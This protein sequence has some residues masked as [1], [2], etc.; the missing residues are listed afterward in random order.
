[1]GGAIRLCGCL[2]IVTRHRGTLKSLFFYACQCGGGHLVR[3]AR[4]DEGED[5][6]F[7]PV[8]SV[9]SVA[10]V[11]RRKRRTFVDTAWARGK[12]TTT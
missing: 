2:F 5:R 7:S 11:T 10:G 9:G 4:G 12:W 3:K 6:A 1:M 8:Q